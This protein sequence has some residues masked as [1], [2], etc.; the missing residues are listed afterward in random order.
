MAL[1]VAINGTGRI[2]MIVAKIIKGR[3][4]IELVA[5]NTT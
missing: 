5:L 1:K 3:D 4:E 2:G